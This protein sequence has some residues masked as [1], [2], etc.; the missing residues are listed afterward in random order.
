MPYFKANMA[1]IL[2]KVYDDKSKTKF[3]YLFYI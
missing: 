2:G 3:L 1:E